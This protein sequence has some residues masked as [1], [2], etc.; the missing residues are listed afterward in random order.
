MEKL[1]PMEW[2]FEVLEQNGFHQPESQFSLVR[3]KDL[4]KK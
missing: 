1:L 2:I 3:M 4:L